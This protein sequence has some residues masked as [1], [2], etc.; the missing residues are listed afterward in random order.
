MGR[1]P[2]LCMRRI[3]ETVEKREDRRMSRADIEAVLCEREGFRSDNVLRAIRALARMH[4]CGYTERR[5]K[6]DCIVTLPTPLPPL[7]NE[8]VYAL[9]AK[10]EDG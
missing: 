9:I 7:S 6:E 1:G 5:F 8:E 3:I 2:G 10:L 4:E